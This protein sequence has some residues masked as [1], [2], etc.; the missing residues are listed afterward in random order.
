MIRNVVMHG[1]ARCGDRE[2]RERDQQFAVGVS[3]RTGQRFQ[4]SPKR[5]D[6]DEGLSGPNCS[7]AHGVLLQAVT[8]STA[9][10]ITLGPR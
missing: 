4:H 6:C 2:G 1:A 3:L 8:L 10:K 5:S 9:P 7:R